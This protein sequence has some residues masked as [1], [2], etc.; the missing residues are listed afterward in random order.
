MRIV[1]SIA[2]ISDVTRSNPWSLREVSRMPTV[3]K[4]A[5][6]DADIARVARLWN[7]LIVSFWCASLVAAI[8]LAYVLLIWLPRH[9][10]G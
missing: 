10:A 4:T 9:A 8:A 7:A 1:R 2:R 5:G 3:R 6:F